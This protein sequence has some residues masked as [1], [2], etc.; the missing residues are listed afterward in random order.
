VIAISLLTLIYLTLIVPN[1]LIDINTNHK[2]PIGIAVFNEDFNNFIFRDPNKENDSLEWRGFSDGEVKFD[3]ENHAVFIYDETKTFLRIFDEFKLKRVFHPFDRENQVWVRKSSMKFPIFD[4]I[5]NGKLVHSDTY[6][7]VNYLLI[8]TSSKII[9]LKA[10]NGANIGNISG[11]EY[12]TPPSLF[13]LNNP[14]R[15]P[16]FSAVKLTNYDNEC[17]EFMG[18]WDCIG[19]V[20]GTYRSIDDA[21]IFIDNLIKEA[22]E[23]ERKRILQL[24]EKTV[25]IPKIQISFCDIAEKYK[26][27]YAESGAKYYR[28]YRKNDLSKIMRSSKITGWIGVVDGK[29]IAESGNAYVII[30]LFGKDFIRIITKDHLA[31]PPGDPLYN[32]I[33]TLKNGDIVKFNGIFQRSQEDYIKEGSMFTFGSMSFPEY[34]IKFTRLERLDD[35]I[36]VTGQ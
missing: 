11:N 5:E 23:S 4:L 31:I 14:S 15:T 32:T 19:I 35:K 34:I 13:V 28:V 27:L 29:G 12:N 24:A 8:E 9:A 6:L 7:G 30:K 16:G 33:M 20:L 21:R 36:I 3:R 17:V 22:K 18:G 1:E 2:M 26:I 25:K 10:H